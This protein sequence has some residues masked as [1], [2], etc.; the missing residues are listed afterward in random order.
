MLVCVL[1]MNQDA[2]DCLY[3]HLL[4]LQLLLPLQL[5]LHSQLQIPLPLRLPLQLCNCVT[6][7]ARGTR[8]PGPA[9]QYVNKPAAK[10]SAALWALLKIHNSLV[11]LVSC[12]ASFFG[13]CFFFFFYNYSYLFCICFFILFLFLPRPERIGQM[14]LLLIKFYYR[15]PRC[16]LLLLARKKTKQEVL[17]V[18]EYVCVFAEKGAREICLHCGMLPMLQALQTFG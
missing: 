14:E 16:L 9:W 5:E 4:N 3:S 18:Y 2:S 8:C 1:Q 6:E 17:W 13:S 15:R 11:V 7:T 12:C 10:H